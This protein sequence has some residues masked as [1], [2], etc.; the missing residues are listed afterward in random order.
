MNPDAHNP[1]VSASASKKIV[2]IRNTD[3]IFR[4]GDSLFWKCEYDKARQY[5]QKLLIKPSISSE[6]LA[7]CYNSLG[8]ANAKLQNYEEA[9]ENYYSEVNVLMKPEISVR[10]EANIAKCYMS[11]GMVYWLQHDHI[12]AI[13]SHKQALETLSNPD[14][15]PDLIS[16]IYKNLANLYTKTKDF[17]VA[18]QYFE[19]ALEFDRSHSRE[20]HLKLG[21]TYADIGALY[22][23]QQD[24]KKAR[25]YCVQ[26]R[27]AWLKSLP[28][29][30]MYIETME[31]TIHE[32][33]L[34]LGK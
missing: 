19:K 34:N 27:D 33:E 11:I 31:K 26:A 8:A 9:I 20:N 24:Y 7:R 17:D 16:N 28:S 30:S 23:S 10:K 29:S 21:Q 15:F 22:Y 25:S 1:N 12:Q 14:L 4:E 5:F 13:N 2:T 32:I 6:N 18:L 3:D